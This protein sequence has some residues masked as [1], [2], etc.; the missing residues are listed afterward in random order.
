MA[1]KKRRR[2]P[3]RL[4][5]TVLCLAVVLGCVA[6]GVA[7]HYADKAKPGVTVAGQDVQGQASME[8]A[9]VVDTLVGGFSITFSTAQGQS[10]RAGASELGMTFD[11]AATIQAAIAG[12]TVT[13]SPGAAEM[14]A[15]YNPWQPKNVPLAY[16][17]DDA[18]LQQFLDARLVPADRE[19]KDA[20]VVYDKAA[21]KFAVVPGAIGHTVNIDEAKAAIAKAAAGEQA[22]SH[23]LGV[24]D[25]APLIS[26]QAAAIAATAANKALATKLVFTSK[27][28]SYQVPA[29]EIASWIS[30]APAADGTLTVGYDQSAATKFLPPTLSN[31]LAKPAVNAKVLTAKNKDGSVRDVVRV[32]TGTDGTVVT[33]ES[34]QEAVTKAIAAL[35]AGK[36]LKQAVKTAVQ[37]KKTVREGVPDNYNE[38]NGAKW[39][40]V[41]L[42]RQTATTYRGTTK[43]KT[44]IIA[45]GINTPD[46][47]TDVGTWYVWL[48]VPVQTMRGEGYVTPNVRWISYFHNGEGFHAAPWVSNF[49]RPHSH[50]CINMRPAEALELY[51]WA[52]LGTKV[53]VHGAT[54]G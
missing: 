6:G 41:N 53:E 15:R 9:S 54:P 1:T 28:G 12:D 38:P 39:I 4:V 21:K 13:G 33:A 20:S 29:A 22:A 36:D 23:P 26:D 30:F 3:L 24:A 7:W 10:V 19:P 11:H 14:I 47:R 51:N 18:A 16:S 52:P 50:G 44:Y 17:V 42:A 46:R 2:W 27:V 45:S 32:N 31:K 8:L 5:I 25:V 48:K 49:G 43:V 35:Q 34:G 37:E 40:D